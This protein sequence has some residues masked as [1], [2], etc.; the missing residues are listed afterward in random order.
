MAIKKIVR[1]GKDDWKPFDWCLNN[2]VRVY[3][4]YMA[5]GRYSVEV[6]DNGTVSNS[7]RD[8]GELYG[9]DEVEFK[10]QEIL[11]YYYDNFS[12]SK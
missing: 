3:V 8:K 7:Y 5:K 9:K 6:D 12:K 1:L 4:V 10:V 2:G 11:Q